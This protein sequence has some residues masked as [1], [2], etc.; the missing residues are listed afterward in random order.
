MTIFVE[1]MISQYKR[2]KLQNVVVSLEKNAMMTVIT[3][4]HFTFPSIAYHMS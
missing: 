4:N 1:T 2:V 3:L